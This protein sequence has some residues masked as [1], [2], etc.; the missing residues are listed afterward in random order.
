MY[1]I[2]L[3][4]ETVSDKRQ[5]LQKKL[6]GHVHK[7]T[8]NLMLIWSLVGNKPVPLGKYFGND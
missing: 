4:T 2:C 8:I 7:Q 5:K 1:G 6:L 3:E